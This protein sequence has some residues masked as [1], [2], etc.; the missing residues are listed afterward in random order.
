MFKMSVSIYH[1][2]TPNGF[3]SVRGSSHLSP[4]RRAAQLRASPSLSAR[5]HVA[6]MSPAGDPRPVPGQARAEGVQWQRGLCSGSERGPSKSDLEGTGPFPAP[7][8]GGVGFPAVAVACRCSVPEMTR[9]LWTGA[10]TGQEQCSLD[11]A[12]GSSWQGSS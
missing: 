9:Q 4:G 11:S 12:G 8:K 3:V 5:A 6:K 1:F 10:R 2:P 7:S